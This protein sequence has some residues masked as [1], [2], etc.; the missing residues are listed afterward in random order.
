ML[1]TFTDSYEEYI[2]QGLLL[3]SKIQKKLSKEE[4]FMGLH[5]KMESLYTHSIMIYAIIDQLSNSDNSD[6]KENESLLLCLKN[7][8]IQQNTI[9]NL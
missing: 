4:P 5:P 9:C 3:I 6:P 2:E 7:Y 1:V 8:I